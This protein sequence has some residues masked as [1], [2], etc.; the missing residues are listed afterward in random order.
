[1]F[2]H[3]MIQVYRFEDIPLGRECFLID[4]IYLEEYEKALIE[5]C[6]GEE[7]RA[8][9]YISYIVA[10]RIFTNSVELSWYPNSIDR[11]HEVPI[12]LPAEKFVTCVGSYDGGEKPHIFVKHQWLESLFLRQYSVFGLI[13]AIG[14]K[15]SIRNGTLSRDQLILLRGEIDKLSKLYPNVSFLSFGDS[16]LLKSN[17]H[18]GY[19]RRGVK[20]T[21]KPEIFIKLVKELQSIYKRTLGLNLYAIFTQGSNEYYEDPLLHYSETKNH[22][23]INSLGIPFA[24]C[25]SIDEAVRKAIKDKIHKPSE[26]YMDA[27]FFNS[28]NFQGI[29]DKKA[30]AQNTYNAK[31]RT[32]RGTYYC[33]SCQELLDHL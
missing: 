6:N 8:V 31:M 19:F 24:D 7:Y 5:S 25:L 16:L 21:Y 23:C 18:V 10:K 32:E 30:M 29:F 11:Y 20:C 3:E 27:Q 17:W 9:G 26:L 13:D 1:M 15:D 2:E 33:Q 22:V 12:V 4:E 14:V 28:L